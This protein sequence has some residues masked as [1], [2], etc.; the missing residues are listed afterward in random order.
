MFSINRAKG[1]FGACA[2]LLGLLVSGCG[3]GGGGGDDNGGGGGGDT[4]RVAGTVFAPD[5]TT[6]VSGARVR[7]PSVVPASRVPDTLTQPDGTFLL[8]DV[9]VGTTTVRITKGEWTKDF[10]IN[11]TAGQTSN[12]PA[13]ATTI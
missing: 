11:V 1:T 13:S 5:G 3:G 4:G 6:P 10:V 2:M 9:P 12:A 7:V 8:L